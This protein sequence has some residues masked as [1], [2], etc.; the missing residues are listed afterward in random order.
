MAKKAAG[1][2][3]STPKKESTLKR[4]RAG[5]KITREHDKRVGLVCLAWFLGVGLVVGALFWYFLH[6]IAGVV[7]GIPAGLLAALIVFSR[8]AE[9]SAYKQLEGQPGAAAAA[10]GVLRRGW[11]MQPGIA[12][13]KNQDIVHRVVG[14]P[15]VILVGEGNPQRVRNL[16]SVEKK[17]HA[18]VV[19]QAPIYDIVAADAE[20]DGVVSVKKLSKHIMKLPRNIEPHEITD[21]LQR[22]KALDAMRP[23]LPV[24]KGPMPTSMKAARQAMRG[25]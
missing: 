12:V 2:G 21:L 23:Q 11:H 6:P 16:L 24:P 10:L 8:R 4:L 14:R 17:K 19:G 7:T 25:R 22:L 3:S 15:G 5:Y 20:G 9:R 13:T 1:A 18:R